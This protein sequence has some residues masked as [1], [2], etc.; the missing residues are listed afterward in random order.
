MV[1]VQQV[2]EEARV[3]IATVSRALAGVPT[4]DPELARRVRAA[5]ERLGYRPNRLAGAFRKQTTQTVGVIVPNI[6]NP[7]FPAVLQSADR[8]LRAAGLSLLLADSN[9]DPKLEQ[10]L[11]DQML[12]YPVDALVIS[13]CRTAPARRTLQA[14]SER[15]PVIQIDR[16]VGKQW[17]YVGV[18]QAAGVRLA[19]E[20]FRGLARSRIAYIAPK[21]S[22]STAEDRVRTFRRLVRPDDGH[23][24]L[25]GLSADWGFDATEQLMQHGTLPDAILCGSDLIGAGVLSSLHDHGVAIGTDIAVVAFDNT[26]LATATYPKLTS[27]GQQFEEL[28][29]GAAALTSRVIDDPD[30]DTESIL[31]HPT[32]IPRQSSIAD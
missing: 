10:E 31:L 22:I 5:A 9:N 11:V 14:A 21:M 17:H 19:I 23:V 26:L 27:I 28:G 1:G 24:L 12:H 20:H 15:V 7:F 6:T 4:V 18:D 3:S 30:L 13:V 32:L 2:A 8:Q 29:A 16:R 25:G